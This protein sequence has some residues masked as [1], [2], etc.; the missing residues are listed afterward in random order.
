MT[1]LF[2]RAVEAARSLPASVQDEIAR[3]VL[4]VAGEEQSPIQLTPE[5]EASLAES[6]AQADRRE[7]A[8]DAE[9][10]A[11]WAKYGL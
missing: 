10:R 3:L 8:T 4:E 11:I 9:V 2:D 7:F 1:Q 6:L 5:Q